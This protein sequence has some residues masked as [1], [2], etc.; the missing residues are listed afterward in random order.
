MEIY[1]IGIYE[2]IDIYARLNIRI[3]KELCLN[4]LLLHF[5]PPFPTSTFRASYQNLSSQ[6]ARQL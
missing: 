2:F 1:I 3:L 6:L 5:A 4:L